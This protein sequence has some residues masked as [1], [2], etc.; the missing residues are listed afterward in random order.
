[1]AFNRLLMDGCGNIGLWINDT[2]CPNL[3]DALEQQVYD[4]NG[5]PEKGEGKGDDITDAASY[6]IAYIH[7]IKKLVSK[8][9]E[10]V[11]AME[12]FA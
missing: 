3:A 11:K 8:R 2:K 12:A 5:L 1:M 7:P 4:D 10:L 6:P 9:I